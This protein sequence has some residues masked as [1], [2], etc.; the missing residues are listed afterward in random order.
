M[1]RCIRIY[2]LQRCRRGLWRAAATLVL[3]G[4][5][6]IAVGAESNA[7]TNSG[8]GKSVA[9]RTSKD[10]QE[11]WAN[12]SDDELKQAAEKGD[13]E[14][15]YGYGI[16]QG[17]VAEEARIRAWN[18]T[19]QALSN[20]ENLTKEEEAASLAKWKEAPEAD[21]RKA[22]EAGERGAQWYLGKTGS[23]SARAEQAKAF[24]WVQRAAEQS[25]AV[26][27]YDVAVQRLGLSSYQHVEVDVE[28]G[29]KWLTRSAEHG[30]E[31]AGHKLATLYLAGELVPPDPGKGIEWL[32]RSADHGCPSALYELARRYSNGDGEPR[33]PED[34]PVAL[35]RKS[36]ET[37]Y[38]PAQLL[39]ASYLRRGLGAHEDFV[40]AIRLLRRASQGGVAANR[41]SLLATVDSPF[42]APSPVLGSEDPR[43][44]ASAAL[45]LLDEKLEPRLPLDAPTYRF[46]EVLSA[47]RKATERSDAAATK[48]MGEIYLQGDVVPHDKVKAMAWL[49]LAAARGS[50]AAGTLTDQLKAQLTAEDLAEAG[51]QQQELARA[52]RIGWVE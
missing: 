36:A 50:T 48:I 35:L 2:G 9:V 31:P 37:G 41:P 38:I 52:D 24:A 39:L 15:Q 4:L 30:F 32:Q 11:R 47:Y 7:V 3:W 6:S 42:S 44:A 1:I 16:R 19:R 45:D 33:G 43:S 21:L 27:E 5:N 25:L 12:A 18:W 29:V 8:S 22:A 14:A 49:S 46:A 51:R 26:A 17:N 20:W 10:I 40:D 13:A 28:A 23:A 34:R